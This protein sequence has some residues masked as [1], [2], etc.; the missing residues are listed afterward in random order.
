MKSAKVVLLF[1]VLIVAFCLTNY[2]AAI[3]YVN[4]LG[5]S[6]MLRLTI[7]AGAGIV[8][9]G[10][11]FLICQPPR[12]KDRRLPKR[13]ELTQFFFFSLGRRLRGGAR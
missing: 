11:A 5:L 1:F 7:A 13:K 3:A 8:V 4:S 6:A 10:V 2:I 12:L 9:Y